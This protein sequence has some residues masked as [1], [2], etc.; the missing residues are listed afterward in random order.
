MS[1]QKTVQVLHISN[2]REF[3]VIRHN[4]EK[5]NP[6]KLY[7]LTWKQHKDGTWYKGRTLLESYADMRSCLY[8]IVQLDGII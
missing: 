1:E 5:Y 7:E 4:S 8:H 2:I 3:I 6:F